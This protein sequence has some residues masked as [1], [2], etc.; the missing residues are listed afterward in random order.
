[1]PP[2]TL[3]SIVVYSTPT[4]PDC[5]QLKAWLR[6]RKLP[7]EERDVTDPAI[8]EEARAH[9]GVRVAPITVVDGQV[10][11]GTFVSQKPR[12][13]RLLVDAA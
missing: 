1:M 2:S 8:A 9:T 5:R 6:D 4:C 12:L 13:E 11:F 10:L 3:P 7:F